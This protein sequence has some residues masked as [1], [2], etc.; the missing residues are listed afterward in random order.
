MDLKHRA[1]RIGIRADPML[2]DRQPAFP[3]FCGQ[4]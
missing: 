2:G 4:V 3:T 1:R